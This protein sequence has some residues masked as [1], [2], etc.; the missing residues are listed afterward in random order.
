M[1][2]FIEF[3]LSKRVVVNVVF[4]ILLI[5]GVNSF[6][7]SPVQNMPPVDI[8]QVFVYTVYYGASPEDVES[9]VTKKLEDAIEDLENVEYIQS[10]SMRNISVMQVK[11]ID[12]SDYRDLYDEMRLKILNIKNDLPDEVDEPLF[13]YVDTEAFLPVIAVNI[14]GDVSNKTLDLLAEEL[15]T[16]LRKVPMVESISTSGDFEDEFHVA[17][18]PQ[19]LREYGV[20][21][22]EA[23]GAVQQA[24]SKIPAGVF[25]KGDTEYAMDTGERFSSQDA[26]L[27]AVVRKDGDGNFIRVR[28]LTVYAGLSNRDPDIMV[29]VN[30][31]STVQLI[32][33]KLRDGDTGTIAKAVRQ[34]ADSFAERHAGEGISVY[35]TQDSTLEIE[36][37]V[38]VL[39]GNM[40]MG[41]AFVMVILWLVLGFRNAMLTS[42]GIPFSILFAVLM[43]S[44]FGYSINTITIFS[45]VLISGIIVDDSVIIVENI[46]RHL[47]NGKS[48]AKAVRDGTAEIFI[49]VTSSALTTILAFVPMFIMTGSTGDFFAFI[50]LTVI[51]ALAASLLEALIIL[52]VHYYEWGPK[53]VSSHD[54]DD[55]AHV[56]SG[57]FAHAWN[58]YSRVVTSLLNNSV[59]TLVVMTV[60]FWIA[61][62]I[63]VLSATGAVPLIKVKFFPDS[64]YRYHV[65]FELPT[66][67][68]LEV[69]DKVIR[70]YSAYIM[71]KGKAEASSASGYAGF[72][73]DVDYVRHRGHYYGSIIVTLP[74]VEDQEFGDIFDNN[75][76]AYLDYLREDFKSFAAE[77]KSDW[78]VLPEVN[79]FGE[80]SGPPVGKDVNI[81]VTA[82]SL[83][84]A[85]SAANEIMAFLRSNSETSGLQELQDNRAKEQVS[86]TIKAKADKIRE[87]GL[88][89]TTVVGVASGALNGMYAGKF[90]SLDDEVDLK[91][92]LV[93]NTDAY[94]YT[95]EGVGSPEDVLMLPVIENS[96][97]PVY[98]QDVA[99]I[100]YS[101]EPNVMRRYNGKPAIT[102]TAD[103]T[104][105]SGLTPSRVQNL[106]KTE[107]KDIAV[108]YPGVVVAFGGEFEETSRAFRSLFMAFIIAILAI[109]LVLAAQFNDYFQPVLILSA[110]AFAI[111]GVVYGLFLTRST[112]T[113]QSFI[114]VV[115]LAGVAVND[116]LILIDFMNA[117]RR[118]GMAL[119]D[120]VLTACSQRMRPVLITT[121]TTILGLL[122][123]AVGFPNKSLEWSS[124][125][126]AF[127]S[128]LASATLLTLLIVPAEY[129]L[130]ERVRIWVINKRSDK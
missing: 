125:A 100:V 65:T 107:F 51:F 40:L 17:L 78:G 39:G 6:K 122:P 56:K 59:K 92:K 82:N 66:G 64:F 45:F 96:T 123:M 102:V 35:Y 23:A 97:R 44:L 62:A 67:T 3:V 88:D 26:V 80:N 87:Y 21:F 54:G 124:M 89:E 47:Q 86:F 90:R 101:T 8:G 32:V 14:A 12:D 74:N 83:E 22:A 106:V 27:D 91:V 95:S 30:G 15:K 10:S 99:E 105:N 73:E 1:K 18:S 126:T 70:D 81:R 41:I 34:E 29:S 111:I 24:N 112:F 72:Y 94:N 76:L 109:Y 28:D 13:I 2:R 69:T 84:T 75:A 103:I 77:H 5:A 31:K 104:D 121:V 16:D 119:R 108:K 113:V 117:R 43:N 46:Y 50:P 61:V 42:V 129:E 48:M 93:K 130:L 58:F 55:L 68:P 33:K 4:I 120:A 116:S 79:I 53:K 52:P 11:F 98:L 7:T 36:D 85:E 19:R 25:R 49:P 37:S 127:C 118:E 71:A 115:G 60:V 114:A 128:G 20:S 9:L 57:V 110:I 38:H 63:L